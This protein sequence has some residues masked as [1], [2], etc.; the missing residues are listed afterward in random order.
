VKAPGSVVFGGSNRRS[1]P[2]FKLTVANPARSMA[3]VVSCAGST[4][5]KRTWLAM[6][7][8]AALTVKAPVAVCA[9][10]PEIAASG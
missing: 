1:P 8:S 3:G 9:E 4:P 6:S 7:M 5:P 2:L 10:K